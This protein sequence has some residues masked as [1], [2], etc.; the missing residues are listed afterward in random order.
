M[1]AA[2]DF[3]LKPWFSVGLAV[4][5]CC[6][7]C[8]EQK[9]IAQSRSDSARQGLH[10]A[11]ERTQ[12]SAR[13]PFRRPRFHGAAKDASVLRLKFMDLWKRCAQAEFFGVSRVH[14]GDERRDEPLQQLIS[15]LSA[16]KR[17]DGFVT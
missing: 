17:G 1:I 6:D 14:A 4:L 2:L 5:Q 16:N 10:A 15:K 8:L 3:D 9:G 12:T 7:A 11:N 13:S